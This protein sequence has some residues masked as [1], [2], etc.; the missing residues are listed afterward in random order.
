VGPK[1]TRRIEPKEAEKDERSNPMRTQS[2]PFCDFFV[3]FGYG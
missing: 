2:G 3:S 1:E